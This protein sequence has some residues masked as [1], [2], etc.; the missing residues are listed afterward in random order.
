MRMIAVDRW[1]WKWQ[2]LMKHQSQPWL[3]LINGVADNI[4]SQCRTFRGYE[5]LIQNVSNIEEKLR[6]MEVDEL[7]VYFREVRR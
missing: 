5:L 4:C 2:T 3:S 1:R 7:V 6:S